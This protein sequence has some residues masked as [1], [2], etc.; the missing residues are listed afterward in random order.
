VKAVPKGAMPTALWFAAMVT[1]MASSGPLD[2]D[3]PGVAGECVGSFGETEEHLG[4][5]EDRVPRVLLRY[6]GP[7]AGG[8]PS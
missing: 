7:A 2:D 8:R 4:S 1:A 6:P 5:V 3:G